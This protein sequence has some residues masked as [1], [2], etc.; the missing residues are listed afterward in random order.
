MTDLKLKAAVVIGS[1]STF[2]TASPAS[3]W[4]D[5]SES[6]GREI[7]RK[8]TEN[9]QEIQLDFSDGDKFG[10]TKLRKFSGIKLLKK[11]VK[12]V[13]KKVSRHTYEQNT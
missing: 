11:A 13:I 6:R 3:G 7:C 8:L 10:Q 2:K 12:K 4:N 9:Y 5:Q 1:D